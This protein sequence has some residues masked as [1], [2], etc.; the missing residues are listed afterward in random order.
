MR[1][2]QPFV[3]LLVLCGAISLAAPITTYG[4][5]TSHPQIVRVSYV[6]GEVKVSTGIKGS[7]DLGKD[8]IAAGVNL[9]IEEGATL[10]TENGRA[11]VEF[12]NGSMAYLAEHSVLQFDRLTSNSQG[13]STEVM[14]L[15]GRATFA[16][17]SN[18]HDEFTLKTVVF[19]LRTNRVTTLRVDSALDGAM[20]HVVEG[21]LAFNEAIPGKS[22]TVGPGDAFQCVGGELSRIEGLQDDPDQKAWDQWVSEERAARKADIDKGLKESGL[23]APIPGLVDLVRGGTFTDCPPYGK[24]WEPKEAAAPG[25]APELAKAIP[26]PR[27]QDSGGQG[28]A[29]SDA[30]QNTG[31]RYEWGREDKGP[32]VTYSGPC[33]WGPVTQ[34]QYWIEKLLKFTP[35]HPEG[36]VV[37]KYGGWDYWSSSAIGSYPAWWRF[38]WATCHAGSWLPEPRDLEVGCKPGKKDKTGKCLP[39]KK[40]W[41]VGPKRKGAS[42]LRVKMGKGE[43]FIP[44]HPLD[45]K[46]KRPLNAK[47]GI[48]TFHGKGVE[49]VAEIK[50]TP[51]NLQIGRSLP[52]GYEASWVKSLPKVEQPVIEGRLLK[53][54]TGSERLKALQNANQ[55]G[56]LSIRYDYKA[57]DFAVFANGAGSSR[58]DARA[59]VLTYLGASQGNGSGSRRGSSGG[60][61]GSS[62]GSRGSSGS[63]R[64]GGGSS[65]SHGGGGGSSRGSSRSSS[66]GNSGSGSSS[67][68]SSSSGGGSGG[69]GSRGSSGGG[70]GSSSS[71]GGGGGGGSSSGSSGGGGRPR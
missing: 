38:P 57:R 71:S 54:G 51:K 48:L 55:K 1:C 20:F 27:T 42:F 7:P 5:E 31:V 50:S 66:H 63:G 17:D 53:G 35:E 64:S 29:N 45:A 3:S 21:F 68:S 16:T 23:V 60:N 30:P 8:W 25:S 39:P 41:V 2:T 33:G 26:E 14:L 19:L 67:H 13:T 43:G 9:P 37:D 4:T 10:A 40:K 15:T 58:G 69:G 52:T 22:F 44:R 47:D 12:E 70:G 61:S 49:E 34:E 11:E 56:Q 24:C 65:G 62:G 6:Q 28:A 46:G 18:G 36:Q 32:L 59:L